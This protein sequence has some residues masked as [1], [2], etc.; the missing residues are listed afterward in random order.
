MK[1]GDTIIWR[2]PEGKNV[3]IW[4]VKGVHLGA[5]GTESLIEIENVSHAPGWTGQWETHVM[6][7]VPEVLLRQCTIGRGLG[8]ANG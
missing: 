1:P 5:P 2:D 6:M 3:H 7:L 4:T 8:A